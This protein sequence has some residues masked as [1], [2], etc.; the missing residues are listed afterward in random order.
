VARLPSHAGLK[1]QEALTFELEEA[2]EF[3]E[4]DGEV[5]VKA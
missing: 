4:K 5:Y 3:V 1:E 2:R